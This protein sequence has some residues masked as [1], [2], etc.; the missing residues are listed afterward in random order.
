MVTSC[1]R[2]IP[3]AAAREE[4]SR[5][6]V[7]IF[8]ETITP[9]DVIR[10]ISRQNALDPRLAPT[11]IHMQRW[12][13]SGGSGL[14]LEQ[15]EA[16]LLPRSVFSPLPDDQAIVTDKIV[17]AAPDHWRSFI[18]D[19]YRSPKPTNLIA[20]SMGLRRRAVYEERRIVL[21]Y[22]LGRLTGAGI[23]IPSYRSR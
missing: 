11:D 7:T 22:L 20:E 3:S 16:E 19:W 15:A 1:R 8:H 17:L 13:V 14:P 10:R 21:A 5:Q 4:M 6:G 18:H 23:R 9:A 12:A 2:F